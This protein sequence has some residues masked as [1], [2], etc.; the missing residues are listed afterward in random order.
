MIVPAAG[1][2]GVKAV[3]TPAGTVIDANTVEVQSRQITLSGSN[4]TTS[5]S[6]DLTYSWDSAPGYAVPAIVGADTPT[7]SVQF[8]QKGL[9]QMVLTVTDRTGS[10]STSTL[11]IRYV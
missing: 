2:S 5:N 6:G 3:I 11:T 1:V 10:K 9:Y 8:A 7:V 4:S